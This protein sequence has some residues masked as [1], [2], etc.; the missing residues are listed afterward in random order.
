MVTG[1][2]VLMI[3][4][5]CDRADHEGGQALELPGRL[6][7]LADEGELLAPRDGRVPL[8]LLVDDDRRPGRSPA[9]RRPR[10]GWACRAGRSCSPRRRACAAPSARR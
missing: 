3:L 5:S 2:T 7:R 8:L 4:S 10:D 6:G 9:A 1:Q